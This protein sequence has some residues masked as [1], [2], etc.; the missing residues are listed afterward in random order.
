MSNASMTS[1]Y[2]LSTEKHSMLLK[3]T[4]C[5][6][7][8]LIAS[9]M[10]SLMLKGRSNLKQTL[11]MDSSVISALERPSGEFKSSRKRRWCNTG[12]HL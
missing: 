7:R 11:V 3:I 10:G 2:R 1:A 8:A 9:L 6:Q 4:A 5:L 12:I